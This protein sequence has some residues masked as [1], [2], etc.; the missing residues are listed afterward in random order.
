M[1]DKICCLCHKSITEPHS[2]QTVY[3]SLKSGHWQV[4]PYHIEC[5]NKLPKC[6]GYTAEKAIRA[7]YYKKEL[8]FS[9][10]KIADVIGTSKSTLHR[11]FKVISQ[12]RE[13]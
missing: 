4:F 3:V 7:E 9:I 1:K 6:L 11:M 8:N 2:Y 10:R 12:L 5:N 13:G